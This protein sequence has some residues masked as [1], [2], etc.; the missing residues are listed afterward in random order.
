LLR[1]SGGQGERLFF[2]YS[3]HGLTQRRDFSNENAIIPSDFSDVL[4]TKALT[5]RSIF[6]LFQATQF[7]EQFV[8]I[9]ACRN[10]PWEQEFRVGDYPK[11]RKPTPPVPPQFVMYATSPGIKAIEIQ[12]AGNEHGAFTE[13]LL[14]GLKGKSTA[15]IWDE[16]MQEYM[17]RW[18]ALFKYVEGE[19]TRKKLGAGGHLIQVPRQAGEHGSE[20]P[21]VGRFPAGAFSQETLDVNLEPDTAASQAEIVVG[22]L[23][24]EVARESAIRQLPVHFTLEPRTYSVRAVA[25]DYRPE[26]GFYP[27]HLY[28]PER[29]LVKLFPGPAGPGAPITTTELTK[30]LGGTRTPARIEV[31][32]ND[33]L[34]KLELADNTGKIIATGE[35]ILMLMDQ[36][37][38]FYRARLIAPE[39]NPVEQLIEL[40]PGDLLPNDTERIILDAPEPPDSALFREVIAKAAIPVEADKTI[41]PSEA[42]GPVATAH[43]STILALAGGAMNED[44][45]RGSKLRR[46]GISS[47]RQIAGPQASSGVQ[48]LFGVEAGTPDQVNTYLSQVKLRCWEQSQPV[49][50]TYQQPIQLPS[51]AG[52]AEFAWDREPGSHWLTI[53]TPDQ[54]PV[55]LAVTVLPQRLTLVVFYRNAAE[56]VNI[57]Q[58]MPSLVPGEPNDPRTNEARFPVLQRSELIQRSYLSGRLEETGRNAEELLYAKWVEPIAG[59]LGGYI[60][61]KVNPTHHLLGIAVGNM[62]GHFGGLSDSYV[63]QAEYLASQEQDAQAAEA[64]R[65]ALDRGLPVLSDGLVRLVDGIQRYQIQHPRAGLAQD[66]FKNRVRGLLW[67]AVPVQDIEFG[68]LPQMSLGTVGT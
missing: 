15:E 48:I 21:E 56:E 11:P 39:G 57:Y 43:L 20:N 16:D 50:E 46:I 51:P 28:G 47:F 58:Y 59:C 68:Q 30:G 63:L 67:T 41:E 10:I 35:G 33:Q 54:R 1:R 23:G 66:V 17:L 37:P 2:Y 14:D 13:A 38:G 40:L 6:E 53:E 45:F 18:E 7:R 25:L 31:R 60:L 8:I 29:L 9:D 27:V 32:S 64:F 62:T 19:V 49:R 36:S 22:H 55:A 34:A 4:T 52:L 42:V 44:T 3:G 24:G 61:L 12:H 5:L 65:S 26:R